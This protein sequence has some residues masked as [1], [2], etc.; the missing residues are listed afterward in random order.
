MKRFALYLGIVAGLVASC[1]TK[2]IDFQT[3]VQD[4]IVFFAS[5]EQPTEEGT[6]VYATEDLYLRWNADDRITIFNKYTYNQEYRFNGE[7][8]DNSGSFK[9]I[10]N[11]DFVTGNYMDNIYAVYPYQESTRISETGTISVSFPAEQKFEDNTFGLDANTMVSVTTDNQLLFRNVGGYLVLKLYGDDVSV[12]S[13]TLKGNNGE[14][15]AGKAT[16]TMPLNGTPTAVMANDATSE[17]TLTC[18]SRVLLGTKAG[19]STQFWFV[20]PPVTFSKGITITVN[21]ASGRVFEKSTSKSISIERNNLSRMASIEVIPEVVVPNYDYRIIHKDYYWGG[22]PKYYRVNPDDVRINDPTDYNLA[23]GI[24]VNKD[25][26]LLGDGDGGRTKNPNSPYLVWPSRSSTDLL[27]YVETYAE[28]LTDVVSTA[29]INP[30]YQFFFAGFDEKGK[31]I[32]DNNPTKAPYVSDEGMVNQNPF[33]TLDG[34]VVSINLDYVGDGRLAVGHTPLIY[35]QSIFNGII[36]AEGFIK[37]EIVEEM[38]YPVNPTIPVPEAVDLGLP[39]GLKWASF[40]LGATKPEEY[41]DYYAWGETEPYYSSQDPLTWRD[42]K[43][44]YDWA[45]YKWCNGSSNTM[46]KYCTNSDYGYNGFSDWKTVL[47]LEDDAA[48]V[49]LGGNWRMPTDA[50]W[51]E[52]MENC[53]WTWTTQNGV[54]GRLV[55]AS[56]GNSIFLPAAG[57]RYRASL[58]DVGSGGLY[59]SSSLSTDYPYLAW[60]AYY[61]SGYVGGVNL[62]RYLGVSVRP[63]YVE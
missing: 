56:N 55:T 46:T 51:T 47:D 36:L 37:L 18:D 17:I 15:L 63:V 23:L 4:N 49:N 31:I 30:E 57:R 40:N 39:S 52:L 12:S 32:I 11:G 29:G 21:D 48:H 45:Y 59:W 10:D 58:Y 2:E 13:I 34:S 6:R 35:V 41:G 42:G 7:T 26:S 53:T 60:Y 38:V 50:E 54:E 14:K 44:G 3:P 27:V 28:Q 9:K 24:D 8:G 25:G 33:V 1:S 22:N 5:F 19:G 20:I 16:V 61:H 62:N 43:T